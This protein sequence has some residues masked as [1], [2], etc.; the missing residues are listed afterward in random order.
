VTEPPPTVTVLLRQQQYAIR[1]ERDGTLVRLSLVVAVAAGAG[2]YGSVQLGP[3][4]LRHLIR[5]LQHELHEAERAEGL[6][7]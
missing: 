4:E 7:P 6:A 3:L 2:A 5:G 1:A